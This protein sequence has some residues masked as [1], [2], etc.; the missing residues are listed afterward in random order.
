VSRKRD[1]A[2]RARILQAAIEVFG[3]RGFR[4]ATI[5][6]IAR[7]CG[8][9]T[10]SVYTYFLS[11][12][13]L[14]RRSLEVGWERFLDEIRRLVV[15]PGLLQ[16]RLDSMFDYCFA[17]LGR[18]LPLLRGML[19]EARQRRLLQD[20]LARLCELF[21]RLLE[22]GERQ[23][24]F[25]LPHDETATRTQIRLTVFGVLSSLALA[26]DEQLQKEMAAMKNAV[27][28][29]LYHRLS[30]EEAPPAGSEVRP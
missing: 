16:E 20:N 2:V 21:E 7:S 27:K 28:R 26:H 18:A 14:L 12:E 5:R 1:P 29:L 15:A 10:G 4:S 25:R 11:K 3:E 17:T 19:L 30:L 22:E 24:L 9:S 23:G 13:E 6:D 8:V